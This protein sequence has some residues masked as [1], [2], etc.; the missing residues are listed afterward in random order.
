M[1]VPVYSEDSIVSRG[2]G[3][4]GKVLPLVNP[5]MGTPDQSFGLFGNRVESDGIGWALK[6]INRCKVGGL[7]E[8]PGDGRD[9]RDVFNKPQ[10]AQD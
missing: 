7:V 2:P 1:L 4:P 3:L 5:K 8:T 6:T 9:W 10:N